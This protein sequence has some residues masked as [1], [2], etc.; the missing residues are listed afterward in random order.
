MTRL[1]LSLTLL[2]AATAPV[3]ANAGTTCEWLEDL[4]TT[5]FDQEQIVACPSVVEQNMYWYTNGTR[6][7]SRTNAESGAPVWKSAQPAYAT[8]DPC[9]TT[10]VHH[11]DG[12]R[13]EGLPG[14]VTSRWS[15]PDP[16]VEAFNSF[17]AKASTG[18]CDIKHEKWGYWCHL[19]AEAPPT[20]KPL[21]DTGTECLSADLDDVIQ[22]YPE[23]QSVTAE[24]LAERVDKLLLLEWLLIYRVNYNPQRQYLVSLPKVEMNKRE[25]NLKARYRICTRR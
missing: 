1:F 16:K 20:V 25:V 3:S 9:A 6:R 23:R 8:D 22:C 18:Q 14:D 13:V 15:G 11:T 5:P 10:F 19:L 7:K 21:Q 2:F 4:P 17:L 24:Y 12:T